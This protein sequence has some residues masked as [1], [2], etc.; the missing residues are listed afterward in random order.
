MTADVAASMTRQK[1]GTSPMSAELANRRAVR[2]WL[3]MCMLVLLTL[4]VVGGATRLTDSGLSITEWKPIHGVIPPLSEAEWQEELEKYRQI[5]EYQLINK[6]MSMAE[7]QFIF[8]WEWA[9]RFLARALGLVVAVP[10]AF[11]WVTG[12]L[13]NRLKLPLVI[14]F[15]L[16]GLQGFIGWWMVSSGLSERVDVSHYR[17][18]THLTMAALILGLMVWIARGIAPHDR[19]LKPTAWSHVAAGAIAALCL[20]QIA[21]GALVAGMDAGIG[22]NEWP[23]MGEGLFPAAEWNSDLGLLNLVETA[24]IVQFV[25]RTGAYVLL[26]AVFIHLWGSWRWAP[27]ST[28]ARR[29]VILAA[30]VTGQAIVGI[31]TLLWEVP[32]TMALVHQGLAFLVLAFAVA[33]FRALNGTMPLRNGRLHRH[34]LTA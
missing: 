6:G 10:L 18:A 12:R 29:A 30:L 24:P 19:D 25:H 1:P 21:L 20:A 16:G 33:H 28:H 23:L 5:P 31:L 27:G 15:A 11:F 26:A 22:Y 3:Y 32:L 7:F 17:L 2:I 8:W 9:H 34:G 4:V 13:D 14:L